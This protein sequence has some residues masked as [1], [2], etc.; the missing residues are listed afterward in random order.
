[1][2]GEFGEEETPSGEESKTP[3]AEHA[4]EGVYEGDDVIGDVEIGEL[5]RINTLEEQATVD[6]NSSPSERVEAVEALVRLLLLYEQE[7]YADKKVVKEIEGS[8]RYLEQLNVEKDVYVENNAIFL[9]SVESTREKILSNLLNLMEGNG[10]HANQVEEAKQPAQWEQLGIS[11]DDYARRQEEDARRGAER[12]VPDAPDQYEE[13][14]RAAD[15]AQVDEEGAEE[16]GD[17][18]EEKREVPK[19]IDMDDAPILSYAEQH[20]DDPNFLYAVQLTLSYLN[21]PDFD[22]LVDIMMVKDVTGEQVT[23]FESMWGLDAYINFTENMGGFDLQL[24]RADP[25]FDKLNA[26]WIQLAKDFD[27]LNPLAKDPDYKYEDDEDFSA[28]W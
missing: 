6:E 24:W 27:K 1:M 16:G 4:A 14:K 21:L 25:S 17:Q 19:R 5:E 28:A 20:K 15:Q 3:E 9:A 11:Q 23:H 2:F 26:E 18:E 7:V 22:N 10:G 12:V 13:E 8:I